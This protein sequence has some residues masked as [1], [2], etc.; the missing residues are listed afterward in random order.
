ML[1]EQ[2]WRAR[3]ACTGLPVSMFFAEQGEI[4]LAKRAQAIC[5][6]C[7]VRIECLEDALSDPSDIDGFGIRGGLSPKRRRNLRNS[8]ALASSANMRRDLA[9]RVRAEERKPV[10]LMWD[11]ERQKYVCRR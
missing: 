4:A 6:Q 8:R 9:D 3:A 2:D 10:L 11:A 5:K 1:A 7:P